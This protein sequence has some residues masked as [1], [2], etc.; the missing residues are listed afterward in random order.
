[1]KTKSLIIISLCF[2]FSALFSQSVDAQTVP[3]GYQLVDSV[4][5][6]PAAVADSSLVGRNVFEMM[7]SKSKGA[8]ADVNVYQS[9]VIAKSMD[10]HI[11]T[12]AERPLAGY[13]VRIFFDN[14]QSARNES[15][16]TL[17]RFESLYHDVSAYRSYANPYFKVTVGDF[18]AK[19][20][21]MELLE[22]IKNEFP[23]AFVVKEN[24]KFPVVDK[25]DAFVTDTV[26]VLRP[27]A[28]VQQ[29]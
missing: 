5:Y 12:N 28:A 29:M 25:N 8:S 16:A 22:R 1:M 4:V 19:S 26:K 14:K 6:R 9:A 18:R 2:I 11:M 24:I 23:S 15:E 13:R 7:P 27:L 20:E 21:A 10:G 3:E 17:K